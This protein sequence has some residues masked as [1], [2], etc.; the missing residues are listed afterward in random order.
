[1]IA[2]LQE[3]KE[4]M[5][6]ALLR[7]QVRDWPVLLKILTRLIEWAE[8]IHF[9]FRPWPSRRWTNKRGSATNQASLCLRTKSSQLILVILTKTKFLVTFQTCRQYVQTVPVLAPAAKLLRQRFLNTIKMDIWESNQ[10]QAETP[11]WKT[12]WAIRLIS[13]SY[14]DQMT[15]SRLLSIVLM[16]SKTVYPSSFLRSLCCNKLHSEKPPST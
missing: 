10:T 4:L 13:T 1:M 8:A 12:W 16:A 11:P 5:P 15:L 7:V 6:P 9:H 3:S 14:N 2:C